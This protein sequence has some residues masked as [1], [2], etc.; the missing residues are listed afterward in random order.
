MNLKKLDIENNDEFKDYYN[1]LNS[2]DNHGHINFSNNYKNFTN[3]LISEIKKNKLKLFLI[4]DDKKIVNYI[5]IHHQAH[6]NRTI[7]KTF[8]HEDI[9]N[10]NNI[11]D[12][13]DNKNLIEIGIRDSENQDY[14]N[15]SP[16]FKKIK[17]YNFMNLEKKEFINLSEKYINNNFKTHKFNIKNDLENLTF[18][19]NECFK[20]HHGYEINSNNDIKEEI[21]LIEQNNINHIEALVSDEGNWIAYC[22]T[23]Y[24]KETK[25][26]RLSMVG[27]REGFRGN[28]TAKVV[29]INS[30]IKIFK[31]G[32]NKIELEVDDSNISAK[33]IYFQLGF[34]ITN[35]LNWY[36]VTK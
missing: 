11:F 8:N 10:F 21:N 35:N 2:V 30:L 36:E 28:G 25:S 12:E 3:K 5:E 22:W 29:I 17:K 19:Q 9:F 16:K 24:N 34:S 4:Y 27:V 6:I 23:Y 26:G 14:I 18:I 31:L 20:A 33:K 1:F 13:I 32:C 7:L 15:S